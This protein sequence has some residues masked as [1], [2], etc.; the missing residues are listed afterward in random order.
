VGIRTIRNREDKKMLREYVSERP[1]T[2]RAPGASD[3][4]AVSANAVML[5]RSRTSSLRTP[6]R[7]YSTSQ[8][9]SIKPFKEDSRWPGWQVIIGIEVHAQI[10]SR[11]KLFSR[12]SFGTVAVQTLTLLFLQMHGLLTSG[13]RPIPVYPPLMLRFREH[14]PSAYF[15]SRTSTETG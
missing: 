12:Q 10:K 15:L 5:V 3:G 2:V 11:K 13:V 14:S 7:L 9:Q 8:A 4:R 1:W 6:R